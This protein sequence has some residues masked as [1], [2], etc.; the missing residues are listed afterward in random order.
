[1]AFDDSGL[2]A[3]QRAA[4]LCDDEQI[5]V[6]AGAGSGK[7]NTLVHRVARLVARGVA[8]ERIVLATFTNRAARAMIQRAAAHLGSRATRVRAGTF[9]QLAYRHLRERGAEIGLP[10]RLTILDRRGAAAALAEAIEGP[11]PPGLLDVLS[12]AV[13][14]DVDLAHAARVRRFESNL[15]LEEVADRFADAKARRGALDFDD[16]LVAFELLLLR[17]P[18]TDVDH[19]LVDE[20]QDTNPIQARIAARLGGHRFAVGD[21]LQSIYA[22]RGARHANILE[23]ADDPRTTVFTLTTT[24][25][26]PP[27]VVRIANA[28]AAPL[29]RAEPLVAARSSG[30]DVTH[31]APFDEADEAEQ[32][33]NTIRR[34]LEAGARPGD[35]AVLFRLHSHGEAIEA[36]LA[37]AALPYALR[38][39]RRYFDATPLLSAYLAVLAGEADDDAWRA[40]IRAEPGVGAVT[41]DRAL[42]ATNR[43]APFTF[44]RRIP[45]LVP[46]AHRLDDLLRR[47]P[48]EATEALLDTPP[49]AEH[50]AV[51]GPVAHLAREHS[52][53][54]DLLADVAL[55]SEPLDDG[56][57]HITLSTVHQAKGLEWPIVAVLRVNDG[58]FPPSHAEDEDE[59]RR[60]L[61]VAATRAKDS[62]ILSV[63]RAAITPSG[64]LPAAPSRFIASLLSE[65]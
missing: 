21:A 4:V 39:A 44:L 47:S 10:E 26:C 38:G 45:N 24:Y 7:T 57:D 48:A 28:I 14:A 29:P 42:V 36:A 41:A 50:R 43:E 15:P 53:F 25:R 34:H 2:D 35:I 12:Y 32:L 64:P 8:P 54:T 11:P 59:E 61:F 13:N 1:M 33:T 55:A 17:R 16:L 19:V 60:L 46:L 27:A 62:L 30:P 31:L 65:R 20:Y 3:D 23:L 5:L 37:R 18:P 58:A 49:F 6:L 51:L 40:V 63:P 56:R 52:R 9:H 22:F